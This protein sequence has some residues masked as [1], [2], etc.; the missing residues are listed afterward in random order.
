MVLAEIIL[1]KEVGK[2]SELIDIIMKHINHY[3]KLVKRIK[4]FN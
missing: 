4:S 2:K 3:S 1:K